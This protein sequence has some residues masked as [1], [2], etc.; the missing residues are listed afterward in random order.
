MVKIVPDALD[1]MW[2]KVQKLIRESVKS[3]PITS[4]L[5]TINDVRNRTY[6][7]DYQLWC[8]FKNGE[9][10]AAALTMV[11]TKTRARILDVVYGA[12]EGLFEWIEEFY[13]TLDDEA[14]ELDCR[15][16]RLEGRADWSS[17]LKKLGFEQAYAA[18]MKEV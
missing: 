4:R 12:G 17:T 11:T 13:Q 1:V 9:V 6:M 15:F 7:G 2:P 5:E 8:I 14:V 16:L 3:S 10:I 18:F